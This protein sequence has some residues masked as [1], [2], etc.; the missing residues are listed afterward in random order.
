MTLNR[1]TQLRK[2]LFDAKDLGEHARDAQHAFDSQSRSVTKTIEAFYTEP[3]VL[4][5]GS[6]EPENIELA[7]I[8]NL[9]AQ[10]TP[11]SCGSMVH[12]NWKPELG[13]A[14]ITSIDGLTP[15]VT[16]KYRFKFRVWFPARSQ[17]VL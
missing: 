2:Q 12:Y 3:M 5:V 17:G 10:E 8:I 4:G 6:E 16:T 11:V 9:N 1:N 14:Q 15:S 13:G 7:R